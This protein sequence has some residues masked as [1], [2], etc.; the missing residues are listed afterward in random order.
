MKN[1]KNFDNF[2]IEKYLFEEFSINGNE[3]MLNES[4]IL[5]KLKGLNKEQ[6]KQY[7]E[8]TYNLLKTIKNF[9]VRVNVIKLLFLIYIS[10]YSLKLIPT[11]SANIS[12][13]SN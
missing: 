7:F 1:L 4:A 10:T 9:N 13:H 5:D 2:I 8:K 6:L 3:Y 12:K 11:A